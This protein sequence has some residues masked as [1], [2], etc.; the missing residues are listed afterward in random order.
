[1]VRP[2]DGV[3]STGGGPLDVQATLA[4][5]TSMKR[6]YKKM[7]RPV[8]RNYEAP[9]PTRLTPELA[10]AVEAWAIKNKI[11]NAA[12]IRR[13]LEQGLKGKR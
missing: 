4:Y 11:S 10:R 12:A 1:M 2:L 8:G 3:S 13:L 7:G 9:I 6:V 5:T